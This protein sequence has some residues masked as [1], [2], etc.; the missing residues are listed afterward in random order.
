MVGHCFF[1]LFFFFL[2][3]DTVVAPPRSVPVPRIKEDMSQ[4]RGFIAIGFVEE[5]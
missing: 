4:I 1:P 3:A 5:Y 2:G